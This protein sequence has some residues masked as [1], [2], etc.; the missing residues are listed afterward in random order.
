MPFE[1]KREKQL[2]QVQPLLVCFRNNSNGRK[3]TVEI[4]DNLGYSQKS[5]NQQELTD[6]SDSS[7]YWSDT[8]DS[9]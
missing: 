5:Y 9:F 1:L 2:R 3:S 7:D 4:V 6:S 8:D